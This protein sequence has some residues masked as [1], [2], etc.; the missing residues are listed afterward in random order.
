M[1]IFNRVS[2]EIENTKIEI[3]FIEIYIKHT[4]D[5]LDNRNQINK[6]TGGTKRL[7]RTLQDAENV[8]REGNERRNERS[9]MMNAASSRSHVIFTI[10]VRRSNTQATISLV[11]LAGSEGVRRT[12][13]TGQALTEGNSINRDLLSIG[14]CLRA[15]S[16]KENVPYRDR[17][18]TKVLHGN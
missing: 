1:D 3:S 14:Q 9:T 4:Y 2:N 5:L 16:S 13:H 12:D 10:H 7:V 17:C 15:L 6:K 8:L 18:I 11:D